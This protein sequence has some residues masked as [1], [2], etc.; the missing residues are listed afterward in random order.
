[1]KGI[2]EF[3]VSGQKRGFKFGTMALAIAEE[4]EG[5]SLQSI[6]K[7]LS[8]GKASMMLLLHILYGAAV[9]YATHAKQ[10]V[11]FT[12]SDVSDWIEEIGFD[13]ATEMISEG[14][15]QYQPKN[16]ESLAKTGE[17]IIQ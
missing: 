17:K 5:K 8:E 11:D 16:S 2:F 15:K 14:F 10:S 12:V 4:K 13:A 7:S 3:E 1:M 6:F 9:Q